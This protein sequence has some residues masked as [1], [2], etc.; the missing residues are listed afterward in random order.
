M[1]SLLSL[2]IGVSQETVIESFVEKILL[3]LNTNLFH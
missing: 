2:N 3:D 1:T